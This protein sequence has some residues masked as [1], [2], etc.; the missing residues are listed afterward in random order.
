MNEIGVDIWY[1]G[2]PPWECDEMGHLNVGFYVAKSSEALVGLAAELGLPQA[3]RADSQT[4]LRV[5]E[6]HIRFLREARAGTA[7]R[8]TGGVVEMGEAD[9]RLLML[10]RHPDGSLAATFQVVVANIDPWKGDERPWPQA[11]RTRAQ[12]LTVAVP[13]E[14]AARSCSLA[15]VTPTASLARAD[16][17]GLRRIG[18]GAIRPSE[19]DVFGRMRT[20]VLMARVFEGAAHLARRRGLKTGQTHDPLA[21]IGG[22]AVEYRLVH[23][24]WPTVGDRIEVRAG[25][26]GA[27]S[28]VRRLMHWALDPAT[29]R[30]WGAAEAAMITFDL[31]AR[32][33]IALEGEAL[34]AA[35]ADIV[36]G[37]A[38]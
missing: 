6:Q 10:L 3:F 26:A 2:V 35:R 21:G 32:K 30:P 13:D 4:T 33:M 24:A 8:M 18:L 22:A 36:P 31:K 17:L 20:E 25:W 38:F 15:P 19:C 1:G 27:E 37:L 29:G 34:R 11:V 9:A 5:R 16:E 23:F 7:L 12:E 28:K 14:A